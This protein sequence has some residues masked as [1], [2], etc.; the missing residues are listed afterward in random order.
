[1]RE[2]TKKMQTYV[3]AFIS[4]DN[5]IKIGYSRNLGNRISVLQ[6]NNAMD[7]SFLYDFEGDHGKE[8]EVLRLLRQYNTRGEWVSAP[9]ITVLEAMAKVQG[10]PT[11]YAV[12]KVIFNQIVKGVRSVDELNRLLGRK[13]Y[14]SELMLFLKEYSEKAFREVNL[15]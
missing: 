6:S 4:A 10:V 2:E 3:Y 9:V 8:K 15:R 11:E 13:F 14:R 5:Q 7:I 1:M 12:G